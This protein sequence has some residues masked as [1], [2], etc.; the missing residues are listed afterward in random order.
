VAKLNASPEAT[1]GNGN[2]VTVLL[3]ANRLRGWT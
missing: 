1:T 3:A 2:N